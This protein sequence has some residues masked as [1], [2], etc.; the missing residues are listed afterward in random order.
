MQEPA[1]V[2][3]D[4]GAESCRV[5]LLRWVDGIPA[6]EVIHR[7]PNGPKHRGDTLYWPLKQI[8][9][10]L[11]EGLRKAA[12]AAPEGIASIGVD[13]WSVDYV[14]LAPDGPMLCEPFCYR[15]ERTVKSKQT[16]DEIISPFDIYQRTGAFPINLNTVYQLMADP[17]AGVDGGAPWVMF[18]EYVLY[19][20]SGRRVGEYTNASHTGL[21]NLK[22]GTWDAE[23]FEML[24][25][26]VEAAPPLVP[27]GTVLGPMKGPL[28]GL[29][30]FRA[31][32]IIAP[33]THDTASAIAGIAT[34]LSSAAYISS[35]T[36]SLVGTITQT[37]VTTHHAF[38]AGYTNIGAAGGGLLFHSLINSMWVLKQCMDGWAVEGRPWKI[39]EIV[40]KAAACNASGGVLDMDAQTF[41]LDSGMP[42]RINSELTRLGFD[43][44]PDVAGN[45]PLFA[46][47]IFESLALRYASALAN[48][49]KML[50]R[51]LDR[52]HMIGGA[53]RNK[54]LIELTEKQTGLKVEIGETESSTVGSLAIQL[55]A[56]EAA[57]ERVA[58]EAI[59]T[60]AE[61]LCR[62]KA[63]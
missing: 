24:G 21:V 61:V 34:D 43:A 18:P 23:L 5:S 57:G 3:I 31:T 29:D 33:A 60:W 17:A 22:T 40:Q 41:M 46:R 13:S 50:G 32:Q 11:E 36:W 35:G 27:T 42:G 49:E 10:G 4:L 19:W 45:E 30:A 63:C 52:I 54:L 53:T 6:V 38:D 7:I 20:L 14:R 62:E 44:I 26:A 2:A 47:T 59:R 12:A 8:L 28:A 37:P 9:A 15:D 39:E 16:A 1:R 25:L 55:A 48:L 56:S 58:P 51:K